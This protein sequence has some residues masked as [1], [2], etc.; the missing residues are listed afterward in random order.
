M[1]T[2]VTDANTALLEIYGTPTLQEFIDY[3]KDNDIWQDS[4]WKDY[5]IDEICSLA[6]GNIYFAKVYSDIKPNGS[7][8]DMS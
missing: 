8:I 2:R 6:E 3:D 7:R 4:S 5:Y 1:A